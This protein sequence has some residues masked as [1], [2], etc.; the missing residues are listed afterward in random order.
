MPFVSAGGTS[1]SVFMGAIGILCNVARQNENSFV[2]IKFK[3][4]N[5]QNLKQKE[6]RNVKKTCKRVRIDAYMHL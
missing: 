6:I 2:S 5:I 1:L 4:M 3:K